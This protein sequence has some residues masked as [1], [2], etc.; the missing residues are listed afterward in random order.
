MRVNV[1]CADLLFPRN[2][3]SSSSRRPAARLIRLLTIFAIPLA[4]LHLPAGL[5]VGIPPDHII[6]LLISKCHSDSVA[7]T[8]AQAGLVIIGNPKILSL[9]PLWRALINYIHI[10]GGYKA[11]DR[12]ARLDWNPREDVNFAD[13]GFYARSRTEQAM[14]RMDALER[15]IR[16]LVLSG[17]GPNDEEEEDGDEVVFVSG[18]ET[19]S[20]WRDNV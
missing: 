6:H 15:R 12:R 5:M 10:N 17:R 11:E 13:E 3:P 7:M 4:L 14:G 2:G 1:N 19:R 16:G 18:Y 20:G 8:R 9:D